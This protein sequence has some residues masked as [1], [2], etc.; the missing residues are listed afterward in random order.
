MVRKSTTLAVLLLGLT[1]ASGRASAQAAED[2]FGVWLNPEDQ[3]NVELHKC[4]EGLCAKI[5]K[6]AGRHSNR[7]KEP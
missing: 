6:V 3:S 4:G 5:T 2:A 1:M 7:R